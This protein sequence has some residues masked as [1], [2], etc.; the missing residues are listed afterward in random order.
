MKNLARRLILLTL[1]VFALAGT[2]HADDGADVFI[3]ESPAIT[4]IDFE[5]RA[6]SKPANEVQAP[7]PAPEEPQDSSG[8]MAD[9]GALQPPSQGSPQSPVMFGGPTIVP[10]TVISKDD[11]L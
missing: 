3:N 8:F 11:T 1:A 4:Q 6:P 7:E 10:E 2:L 5:G 9:D